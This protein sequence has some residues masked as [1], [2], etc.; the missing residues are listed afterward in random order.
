MLKG[1][2]ERAVTFSAYVINTL[3]LATQTDCANTA[4]KPE[5]LDVIRANFRLKRRKSL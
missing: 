1:F 4:I 2:T 5:F 3:I